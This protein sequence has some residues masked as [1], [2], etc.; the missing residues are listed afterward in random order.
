MVQL[1]GLE[2]VDRLAVFEISIGAS[3]SKSSNTAT[4]A[5]SQNGLRLAYSIDSRAERL[6]YGVL[7]P[8][9]TLGASGPAGGW[10]VGAT[11]AVLL[12]DLLA[13]LCH[14]AKFEFLDLAR[15]CLGH[16]S[17]DHMAGTLEIGEVLL[18]PGNHLIGREAFAFL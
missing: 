2:P 17:E 1:S 14:F 18:A 9:A 10:P 7:P 15:R 16:F 3:A 6:R 13:V 11:S 5:G 4:W 8:W 12:A